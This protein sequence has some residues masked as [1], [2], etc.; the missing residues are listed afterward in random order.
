VGLA[1]KADTPKLHHRSANFLGIIAYALHI[2][3]QAREVANFFDA[4]SRGLGISGESSPAYRAREW[5]REK[6]AT[7]GSAV[8]RDT[9]GYMADCLQAWCEKEP[10]A[11]RRATG[12]GLAWLRTKTVR[13]YTAVRQILGF[14]G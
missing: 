1:V 5:A 8:V 11:S 2:P 6:R 10:M 9:V 12:T 14:Q 4:F 13:H 7:I 3:G